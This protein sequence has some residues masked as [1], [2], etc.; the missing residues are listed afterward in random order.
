M[1]SC[2]PWRRE[3]RSSGANPTVRRCS[4][5]ASAQIMLWAPGDFSWL[6]VG[7]DGHTRFRGHAKTMAAAKAAAS[8][9]LR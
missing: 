1:K 9:K 7:G 6:V 8:R 3:S 4:S 2:T 5:G